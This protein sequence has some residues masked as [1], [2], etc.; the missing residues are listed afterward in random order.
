MLEECQKLKPETP[1]GSL[2]I[3]SLENAGPDPF[4]DEASLVP[5]G[6]VPDEDI[7]A[8]VRIHDSIIRGSVSIETLEL[9]V[10]EFKIMIRTMV[11]EK[12]DDN[13]YPFCLP[14]HTI[15]PGSETTGVRYFTSGVSPY[16]IKTLLEKF[17]DDN[18]EYRNQAMIRYLYMFCLQR[19]NIS[20]EITDI[21]D[22]Y[23]EKFLPGAWGV[24][25]GIYKFKMKA[26]KIFYAEN[27]VRRRLV[28][29][30]EAVEQFRSS[31]VNGGYGNL[32]WLSYKYYPDWLTDNDF[33]EGV[34]NEI[35]RLRILKEII[36]DKMKYENL[37][38]GYLYERLKQRTDELYRLINAFNEM[39][40][41]ITDRPNP[42]RA[43]VGKSAVE[44]ACCAFLDEFE[45]DTSSQLSDPRYILKTKTDAE[46][47]K[48]FVKLDVTPIRWRE[49]GDLE[50]IERE[51]YEAMQR[52]LGELITPTAPRWTRCC[53][54]PTGAAAGAVED[55]MEDQPDFLNESSLEYEQMLGSMSG[56]GLRHNRYGNILIPGT[57][58]LKSTK[59]KIKRKHKRTK[60]KRTKQKRNRTKHKRKRTKHKRIK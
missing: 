6:R 14:L 46:N 44:N 57:A 52:R 11:Q 49:V 15:L 39:G 60:H 31:G 20:R 59:K 5:A 26:K 7:P 13:I 41:F 27:G 30:E 35:K 10:R 38:D 12:F 43:Y 34:V 45:R 1:D 29:G 28:V 47:K 22:A 32:G 37:V 2:E 54:T 24:G 42:R 40:G 23:L 17:L 50:A 55:M 58:S 19:G 33:I 16:F 9:V 36:D 3:A 18:E 48:Y 53:T 25:R 56:G 21:R 51:A 8:R 4:G